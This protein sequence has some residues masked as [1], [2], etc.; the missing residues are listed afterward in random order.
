LGRRYLCATGQCQQ[1]EERGEPSV[2]VHC[3]E[4]GSI[5]PGSLFLTL[6][7]RAPTNEEVLYYGSCLPA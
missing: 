4:I 1:D 5:K 3:T 2:Q 6:P 7:T